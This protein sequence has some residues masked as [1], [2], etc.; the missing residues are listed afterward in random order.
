M[1][2]YE[3]TQVHKSPGELEV[4]Y[5]SSLHTKKK[6]AKLRAQ[7]INRGQIEA[8]WVLED[9]NTITWKKKAKAIPQILE[10]NEQQFDV[11]NKRKADCWVKKYTFR[12]KEIIVHGKP[13]LK[14]K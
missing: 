12:I 6:W 10:S 7:L 2:I 5:H 8:P 1:I 4:C 13:K 14:S 9:N 11:I 3:L